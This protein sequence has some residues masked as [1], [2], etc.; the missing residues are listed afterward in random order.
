MIF[1]FFVMWAVTGLL[2]GLIASKVINLRGDDPMGGILVAAVGGVVLGLIVKIASSTPMNEWSTGSCIAG[3]LG[4]LTA[5][6]IW[7]LVRSRYVSH[8]RG[9]IRRSY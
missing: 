6:A 2:V 5:V 9:S 7:H 3:A 4:A 8:T 1:V